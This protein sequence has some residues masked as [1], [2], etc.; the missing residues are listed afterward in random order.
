MLE[1]LRGSFRPEFLNRIDDIVLFDRIRESSMRKIV[2]VQ[3]A[4]VAS[5]IKT[6]KDITLEF[7]DDVRDMLARDGYDP[8]LARDH[9]L[10]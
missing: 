1:V 6:S 10:G 3:L 8:P 5:L 2:D 9:W 4:R 7:A